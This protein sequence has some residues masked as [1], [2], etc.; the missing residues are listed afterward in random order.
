MAT[1]IIAQPIGAVMPTVKYG[2]KA[3]YTLAIQELYQ[4]ARR[5]GWNLETA[6]KDHIATWLSISHHAL[7]A[8]NRKYGINMDD[9]RSGRV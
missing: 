6:T 1:L 5:S 3:E 2:T 4:R 9:I 7:E 8:R